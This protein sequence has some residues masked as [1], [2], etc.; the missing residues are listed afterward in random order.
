[1]RLPINFSPVVEMISGSIDRNYPVE[2]GAAV[3]VVAVFEAAVIDIIVERHQI[4]S[5]VQPVLDTY[6][7]VAERDGKFCATRI[8]LTIC[9]TPVLLECLIPAQCRGEVLPATEFF[10]AEAHKRLNHSIIHYTSILGSIGIMMI[11]ER[12]AGRNEIIETVLSETEG[13][14]LLATI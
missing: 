9:L 10:E 14:E 2:W 3:E 4:F 12:E 7:P 6:I 13:V 11:F 5:V 1:M 8:I